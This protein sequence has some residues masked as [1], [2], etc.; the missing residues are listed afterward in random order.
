[1]RGQKLDTTDLTNVLLVF[2]VVQA[3]S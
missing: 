1:M 3:L 2:N